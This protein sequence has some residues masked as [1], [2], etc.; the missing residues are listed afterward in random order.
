LILNDIETN[1]NLLQSKILAAH[2][3]SCP[4]RTV[5]PGRNAPYWSSDLA[6]LH[7][8]TRK[9]WNHRVN[10][11]EGYKLAVSVYSKALRKAK[12]S[13]FKKFNSEVDGVGKFRLSSKELTKSNQE[14]ADR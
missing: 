14:V 2:E 12:R 3:A 9:A 1:V 10:D 13:S 5:K 7:K 6:I 11:P 4:L 8:A